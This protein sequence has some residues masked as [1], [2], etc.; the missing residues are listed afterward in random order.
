MLKDTKVKAES[1]MKAELISRIKQIVSFED[2]YK[3]NIDNDVYKNKYNVTV[4]EVSI[5]QW[6]AFYNDEASKA[7]L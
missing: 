7:V 4:D 5:S 2:Y 3:R 6:D 1:K